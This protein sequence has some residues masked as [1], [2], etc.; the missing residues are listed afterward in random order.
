MNTKTGFSIVETMIGITIGIILSISILGVYLAQKNTYRTNASQALIQNT[1]SAIAALM[2]PTI[3]SAGFCGCNSSIFALSNLNDGGPPPLGNLSTTPSMIY[4]YDASAGT[5]INITHDNAANS[6]QSNKWNPGLD[7]SLTGNV[8]PSSDIISVF[9]PPIGTEPMGVITITSGSSSFTLQSATSIAAG[10]FGA[11]S[12][13][14]KAT[15]F[16]ITNV[17]GTTISHAAGTG[18]LTNASSSFTANY[19]PGA[20]FVQIKQTAYFVANDPSGQSALRRAT[21]N[22]DGTWSIQSLVPD[23]DT[24]QVL[25]GIGSDGFPAEYVPASAVT[26]WSQVYAVR[27]GF[28]LAGKVGSATINATTYSLLGTTVNVPADNRLRHVFEMTIHLRNAQ[29]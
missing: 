7:T 4:G 26:N 19:R 23:V 13:C 1:E 21:L 29:S 27:V 24:M 16:Q 17:N 11:I 22:P 8:Q 25:Y 10:D 2:I 20:Q 28:L 3:R 15:V 5:T 14:L 12:D 9:G 6:S 18:A